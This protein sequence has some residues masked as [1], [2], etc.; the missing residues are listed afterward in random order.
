MG[1]INLLLSYYNHNINLMLKGLAL[2][3]VTVVL[4]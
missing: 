1:M 3:A 2:Q 4:T